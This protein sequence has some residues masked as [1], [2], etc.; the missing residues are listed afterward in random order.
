MVQM[1]KMIIS[2]GD[3]FSLKIFIFQVVKGLK[4]LKMAQN[5]ENLCLSHLLFQDHISYDLH[6]W[7]TCMYKRIIY[8]GTFFSFFEILGQ[9]M[10]QNDKKLSLSDSVGQELFII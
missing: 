10:A 3:F 7:Y 4:E 2:P 5:D 8:P 6:L 1:C 9:K